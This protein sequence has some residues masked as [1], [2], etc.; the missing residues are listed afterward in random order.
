MDNLDSIKQVA[1]VGINQ[2]PLDEA[3]Q[4]ASQIVTAYP[5]IERYWL[6]GQKTPRS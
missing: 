6:L 2:T 3:V 4:V 5:G 1:K